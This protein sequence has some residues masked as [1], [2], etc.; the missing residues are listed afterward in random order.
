MVFIYTPNNAAELKAEVV[1]FDEKATELN[2]EKE[3][4]GASLAEIEAKVQLSE[5]NLSEA[6]EDG[7]VTK[8]SLLNKQE[9]LLEEIQKSISPR[10]LYTVIPSLFLLS[11]ACMILIVVF[12]IPEKQRTLHQPLTAKQENFLEDKKGGLH[13]LELIASDTSWIFVR[14]DDKE[15]KEIMLKPGE[16]I[17]M[18]AKNNFSLTIGNAGGTKLILDGKDLGYIGDKDQVVKIKLPSPKIQGKLNTNK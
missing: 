2:R 8:V 12:L 6:V 7:D 5:V 13:T 3:Q 16:R 15:S 9:T 10:F 18:D 4:L 11:L 1:A 17:K 14:I